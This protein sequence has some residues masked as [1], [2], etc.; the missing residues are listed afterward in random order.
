MTLEAVD[1]V[2][3]TAPLT[4]GAVYARATGAALERPFVASGAEVDVTGLVE[5]RPTRSI[6]LLP[7]VEGGVE[8]TVCRRVARNSPLRAGEVY[9]WRWRPSD[10]ARFFVLVPTPS[11]TPPPGTPPRV[12]FLVEHGCT[13]V[14]LPELDGFAASYRWWTTAPDGTLVEG[15]RVGKIPLIQPRMW[16]GPY[17]PGLV[18]HVQTV[19]QDGTASPETRILFRLADV[20]GQRR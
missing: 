16:R 19:A 1:A 11:P 5:L 2:P 14:D 20:E 15:L 4:G 9:L 18:L 13:Y 3:A 8:Q 17:P 6:F 10:P 12:G 7:T